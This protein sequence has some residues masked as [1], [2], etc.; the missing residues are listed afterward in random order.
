MLGDIGVSVVVHSML[1]KNKCT[2]I[3]V[4]LILISLLSSCRSDKLDNKRIVIDLKETEESIR[5]SSFVDSVSYLTFH[6]D[7]IP[8]AGIEKIYKKDGYYYIWGEQSAGIFIF[9]DKATVS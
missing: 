8:I 5:Y 1:V 6:F 2:F 7:D 3:L 4:G 9:N